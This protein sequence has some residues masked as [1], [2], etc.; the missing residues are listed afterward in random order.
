MNDNN[1]YAV[2]MDHFNKIFGREDD[3]EEQIEQ[4]IKNENTH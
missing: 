4:E 3:E 1:Y 2:T